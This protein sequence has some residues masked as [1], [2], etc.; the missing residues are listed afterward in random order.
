MNRGMK[1]RRRRLSRKE[2]PIDAKDL[3]LGHSCS[4]TRKIEIMAMG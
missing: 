2:G 4:N 1:R 3:V